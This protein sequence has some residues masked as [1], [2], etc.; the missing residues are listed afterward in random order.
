MKRVARMLAAPLA[1]VVFLLLPMTS[2][3]QNYPNRLT[4]LILGFP[5]GGGTDIIA[6]LLAQKLSE[7]FGQQVIVDNRPGANSNLAA[8]VVAKAPADGYTIFLITG[9][10]A[11]NKALYRSLSYDL[12]RDFVPIVAVGSVPQVISVHPSLPVKSVADLIAFAKSRPGQIVYASAGTG[13]VEHIAAEIF[14]SMA[15]IKML[16][17]QYKG[18]GPAALALLGGEVAAGFNVLPAVLPFIKNGRVRALAVT[19]ERRSSILPDLATVAQSGLPGYEASVW[20]GVLAPNGTPRDIVAKLNT[21]LN[22]IIGLPEVRERLAVLGADPIGG[23]PEA[24]GTLIRSSVAKYVKVV[25]D[26]NIQV[27]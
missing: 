9:G 15:G 24:F 7:G 16:H 6:R 22:R 5:P 21:E 13:S 1:A 18:G 4:R 3:A 19:G 27:E 26:A 14:A 2:A 10:L 20:Y 25:K 17:V 12:E 11:V 8:E 23:S